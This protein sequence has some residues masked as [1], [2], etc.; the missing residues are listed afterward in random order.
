MT[1]WQVGADT[2]VWNLHRIYGRIRLPLLIEGWSVLA[3]AG[4]DKVTLEPGKIIVTQ[5]LMLLAPTDLL[6]GF[7]W[8]LPAS[9][10]IPQLQ[11]LQLCGGNDDDE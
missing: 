6:E 4:F 5:P 9:A 10:C 11:Q 3:S 8:N 2:V 1:L 7:S